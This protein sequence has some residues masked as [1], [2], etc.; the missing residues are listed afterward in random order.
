MKTIDGGGA[1]GA[2]RA[3]LVALYEVTGGAKWK[4]NTNWL[5]AAPLDE[6]KGVTTDEEGRVLRLDLHWNKL[7]G[8][9]PAELAQLKNLTRLSLHGNKLTGCDPGRVS[10]TQKPDRIAAWRQ[11]V[12]GV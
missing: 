4:N 10:P 7:T 11:R 5:S 9:I 2:D 8:S 3:V 12:D 6:W 1:V